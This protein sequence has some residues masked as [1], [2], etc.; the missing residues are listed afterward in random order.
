VFSKPESYLN[1]LL[2]RLAMSYRSILLVADESASA[3]EKPGPENSPDLIVIAECVTRWRDIRSTLLSLRDWTEPQTRLLFTLPNPAVQWLKS[4]R[5]HQENWVSLHDLKN[6]LRLTDFKIESEGTHR[7]RPY[8]VASVEP[9]ASPDTSLSCSVIVPTRNEVGNIRDC[10]SRIPEMGSGTEIIFV[11]GNSSDGTVE[12]IENQIEAHPHKNIRLIHQ[13]T[14]ER[15]LGPDTERELRRVEKIGKMLP[16]GKADAVRK[17][18]RAATGDV[19]M[20]LD[21]DLTVRPEDLPL[22]F[23]QLA[24]GRGDFINGVRLLYPQEQD[25]MK[26]VNLLGNTFFGYALSWLMGQTIKDSL[27]GTKVFRRSDYEAIM[28][29]ESTL[30]DFDPFGDFE[31]LFGATQAGL[32]IVDLP[33]HYG[34]RVAGQPKIET[35]RHGLKLFRMLWYGFLLFK[36]KS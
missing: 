3:L 36:V 33:V 12:T 32:K 8:L 27:C 24:S 28:E 30:G 31:L 6:L 10:V 1:S 9:Q 26:F 25:A 29:I 21:A 35:Y 22:F 34:R 16:Q 17:G 14:P 5:S 11:D 19:L 7:L 18:F 23:D 15:E 2:S 4:Y 13:L 20:I